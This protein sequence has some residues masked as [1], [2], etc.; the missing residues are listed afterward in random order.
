[1]N[2]IEVWLPNKKGKNKPIIP[3]CIFSSFFCEMSHE[4]IAW[5]AIIYMYAYSVKIQQINV[6][7]VRY[8]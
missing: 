6:T 3:E 4:L 2:I 5:T 8:K 1:M 7:V